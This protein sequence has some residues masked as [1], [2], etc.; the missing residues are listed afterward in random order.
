MQ[1][2]GAKCV[3]THDEEEGETEK[4]EQLDENNEVE[5]NVS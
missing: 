5:R 2:E 4:F 1:E 3:M